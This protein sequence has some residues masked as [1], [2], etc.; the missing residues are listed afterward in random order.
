[1]RVCSL[2]GFLAFSLLLAG[3]GGSDGPPTFRVSGKVTLDGQPVNK[4]QITFKDAAGQTK[5]MAA[6][7]QNGAYSFLCTAGQK[8]I[9]IT[10]LRKVEG[11]QHKFG[12]NPGDPIG[13]NNSADIYEE[14]IPAVYNTQTTLEQEVKSSGSN[15]F[16]F[17]LKSK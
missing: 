5:S 12:G 14:A 3:C 16:N 17:D 15:Q 7:V 11:K 4:G 9:E 1:M 2:T 13:P 10:S 8:K 6:E